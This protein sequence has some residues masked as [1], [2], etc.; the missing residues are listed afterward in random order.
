LAKKATLAFT[1]GSAAAGP[2]QAPTAPPPAPPQLPQRRFF[3]ARER[4]IGR[5]AR[6][7]TAK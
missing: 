7:A 5:R 1:G 6:V 2:R 3:F 4:K